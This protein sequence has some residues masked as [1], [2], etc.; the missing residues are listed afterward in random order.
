[1]LKWE[2]YEKNNHGILNSLFQFKNETFWRLRNHQKLKNPFGRRI[3]KVHRII[4][5]IQIQRQKF[6]INDV[7]RLRENSRGTLRINFL[8]SKVRSHDEFS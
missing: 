1:M 3:L 2:K 4:R 7:L 6:S 5:C 8:G